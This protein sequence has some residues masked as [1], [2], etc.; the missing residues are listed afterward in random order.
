VTR[1]RALSVLLLAVV[2]A[3]TMPLLGLAAA[4]H[5]V[6]AYLAFPPRT[7][8]VAHA[9]FAWGA[10]AALS[11]PALAALA[12][13][14]AAIVRA[15][16][17]AAA[18]PAA[19]R[20]PWWGWL[21]LGLIGAGWFLAWNES[22]VPAEWR[23]HPFTALWIGYVLCLNAL[24]YRRAGY[25]LLTDRSAW[26]IALFPVS[27]AFWWLFEHFNQFVDN[28]Y[29][30][31]VHAGSD[32]DYFI[33]ATLPF[34]TVLPAVASTWAWL[35]QVPRLDALALPALRGHPA[36]PWV[37]VFSAVLGLAAIGVWPEALYPMVWLAPLLLL[38]GLQLLLLGE[39]M[40][41]PIAHGDW[42]PLLQPA[43]AGLV[44]GFFWE[45]WNYGSLAKWHYSVPY[46]QRFQLFEMP[47]LG[48]A[49]YLPFGVT[50]ALVMDLVARL[51][52]RRP[53]YRI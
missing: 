41:A 39:A 38:C 53:L 19:G 27:A 25:S 34:S 6:A 40:L 32:W 7:E 51:V 13:F 20:F 45:L 36:L 3:W 5:P 18:A 28:W 30:S 37:C 11:V 29:Y 2:L 21:G 44:C 33:Q 9:P 52:E 10:F 48:Y 46:T 12:L 16:P 17:E 22:I 24:V 42:R 47:L 31:G 1:L 35:R 49:G 4:G 23:R 43:L 50:C 26:F 14:L 15:R 8:Q